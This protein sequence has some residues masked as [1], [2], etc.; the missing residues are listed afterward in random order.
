MK[1]RKK[2]RDLNL[3]DRFLFSEAME[4]KEFAENILSIIMT[5]E[6]ELKYPP[7]TVQE[8]RKYRQCIGEAPASNPMKEKI[9]RTKLEVAD[10]K[11]FEIAARLKK[12]GLSVEMIADG[13]GLSR[14]E[15]E[16]L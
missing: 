15:I 1:K 2:L 12:Q 16:K 11:T 8:A 10:Q 9:E 13:T 6:I 5:D 4:D 7:Q 3:L 14:E